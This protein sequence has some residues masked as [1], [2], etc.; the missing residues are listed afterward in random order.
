ME[1]ER[2]SCAYFF[3]RESSYERCRLKTDQTQSFLSCAFTNPSSLFSS[4]FS[5]F[6]S[7][8]SPLSFIILQFRSSF[9]KPNT[10]TTDPNATSLEKGGNGSNMKVIAQSKSV[11]LATYSKGT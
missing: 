1:K 3:S 11:N 10:T 9:V 8:P 4:S 7:P 6:I 5:S 2:D